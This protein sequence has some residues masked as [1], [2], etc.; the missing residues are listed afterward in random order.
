MYANGAHCGKTITI[1]NKAT[2]AKQTAV[3]ADECPSCVSTQSVDMS[4]GLFETLAT[5]EE[6]MI[7]IAWGFN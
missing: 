3:V 4:R 6:G 1:E 5:L 7:N 2:G